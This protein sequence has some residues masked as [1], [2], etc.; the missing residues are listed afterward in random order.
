MA[1]GSVRGDSPSGVGCVGVV[2]ATPDV[3]PDF[4]GPTPAGAGGPVAAGGGNCAIDQEEP[5]VPPVNYTPDWSLFAA[6]GGLATKGLNLLAAVALAAC[7]GFFVW[8][9]ILTAGGVS[10]QVPHN[11]ARGP[12][13]DAGV[14]AVRAGDRDRRAADPHLLRGRPGGRLSPLSRTRP[15]GDL[16]APGATRPTGQRSCS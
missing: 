8:G 7:A 4:P 12:P 2:P 13:A 14:G 11:V 10:S 15:G 16:V 9:A 3:W 1:G 5:T 6:A